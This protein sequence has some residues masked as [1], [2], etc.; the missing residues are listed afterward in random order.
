M[1]MLAEDELRDAVLLIFA[2]KQV[3]VKLC[4]WLCLSSSG[5]WRWIYYDDNR[6]LMVQWKWT[7]MFVSR[8][9]WIDRC[10][11]QVFGGWWEFCWRGDSKKL[12]TFARLEKQLLR[13]FFLRRFREFLKIADEFQG[14][15]MKSRRWRIVIE[16]QFRKCFHECLKRATWNWMK[17]NIVDDLLGLWWKIKRSWVEILKC[18]ELFKIQL[19]FNSRDDNFFET[20]RDFEEITS[21]VSKSFSIHEI[22]HI[23]S[24]IFWTFANDVMLFFGFW[25]L[26]LCFMLRT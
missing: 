23:I 4:L 13:V 15:S 11:V 16:L 25:T 22:F 1:R 18:F 3:S 9:D 21:K 20:F 5:V 8:R 24:W 19:K 2:N 26:P 7:F 17:R 6:S 10:W 14:F 12:L